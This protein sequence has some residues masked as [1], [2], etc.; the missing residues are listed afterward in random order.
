MNE[1]EIYDEGSS[2]PDEK[3]EGTMTLDPEA[4]EPAPAPPLYAVRTKGLTVHAE[5]LALELPKNRYEQV[6]IWFM[7]AVGSQTACRAVAANI[8]KSNPEAAVVAPN[9]ALMRTGRKEYYTAHRAAQAAEKWSY[10]IAKLPRS[11]AW[12]LLLYNLAQL[13]DNSAIPFILME[14]RPGDDA[15]AARMHHLYL[16]RRLPLPL[17]RN[18]AEWL[19]KQ[20]IK[21]SEIKELTGIGRRLWLCRPDEESIARGLGTQLRAK[22]LYVPEL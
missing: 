21:R 14:Q 13:H 18:W 2:P 12:H 5:T 19:W 7:S 17:H 4:A 8:L 15:D 11:G 16:S 3:T 22:K 1:V 10:K 20:G 6:G 9:E